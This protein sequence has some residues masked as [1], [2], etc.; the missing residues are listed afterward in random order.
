MHTERNVSANIVKH[1]F[2]DNDTPEV[3]KDMEQASLMPHLLLQQSPETQGYTQPWAPYVL[4]E[5]ERRQFLRVV[6]TT[7]TPT[8]FA[9]SLQKH[10][11]KDK[12]AGLKSHDHHVL[13]QQVMPAAIRGSLARGPREAVI[14][15]GNVFQRLCVKV[16]DPNEIPDLMDY[17]AVTL[18]MFEQHFPPSF[19]D[20]MTHLVIH[21]IEELDQCGPVHA[22]WC[23]PIER[24]MGVLASYVRNLWPGQ[25]RAWPLAT[26][27]TKP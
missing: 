14:R 13:V 19:F 10:A 23:Y 6:A 9:S 3:R 12:L 16:V 27:R 18:C 17:T 1:I 11:G 8:G 25:R 24:Y 5:S 7:S 2:G 20:I 4:T 26:L 15:M 22:R 21:L